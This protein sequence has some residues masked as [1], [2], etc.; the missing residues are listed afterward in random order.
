MRNKLIILIL[1]VAVAI[2]LLSAC[3]FMK[4]ACDTH[5]FKDGF[6]TACGES[7]PDY[8]P[9]CT[10][11]YEDGEC[12]K[13]G[14]SDPDY[15]PPCTHAYENGEC[16]K[17]GEADPNY[18]PPCTHTYE[19][20]ECTKCGEADPDYV[21]KISEDEIYAPV[22]SKFQYLILYKYMNEEL[23]PKGANEPYYVDALYDVAAEYSPDNSMGH[24][25]SDVNGDGIKELLLMGKDCRINAIFTVLDGE[26]THVKT[27]P[28]G[29]GYLAPGGMVFYNER[30]SGTLSTVRHMKWLVDGELRGF[31]YARLDNTDGSTE[32]YYK[33]EDGVKTDITEAEFKTYVAKYSYYW[34]YP[35]RLTRLVG[36][37]FNP[38]LPEASTAT[39]VADFSTYEQI[40]KTFGLMYTEVAYNPVSRKSVFE[41]TKWTGGEYDAKMIFDS[42]EDFYVYNSIIAACVLTQSSTS[43]SFGYAIKD[44][45]GDGTD[46]LVLL[47]SRYYVLAI[48]TEVEGSAVLLDIYT[49]T[50][51]AWIDEDGNIHVKE[52]P[53]TGLQ[54][55]SRYYVYEVGSG[56]LELKLAIGIAQQ[57]D[58]DG[59]NAY[60]RYILENGTECDV[61]QE[62]WDVLYADWERDLGV[63]QFH[64]YTAEN[65]GLVFVKLN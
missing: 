42:D 37:K 9:P 25:I 54:E 56:E 64:T 23:P 11:A 46:E 50:R 61:E 2:A 52:R 26:L 35:T 5:D 53:L 58:G 34:D 1:T 27:F 18:V 8:V 21:P 17:C 48:F 45:N 4:P 43:A 28:Q 62:A 57:N 22:I 59:Q 15:V 60:R 24:A 39:S 7:D 10:H 30:I 38:A 6:C 16:T 19:N 31:E 63:S 41:R 20:G 44:L 12:T 55:D 13:C 33:V 36:L 3:D 40:I 29:M 51:S 65:S 49:D 14:E 32:G 47:E